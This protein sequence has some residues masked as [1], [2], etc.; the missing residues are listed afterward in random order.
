M[1]ETWSWVGESGSS[2]KYYVYELTWRPR[3][4]QEE[5]YIFGA[6]MHG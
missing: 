3:K 5:H 6:H 2:Y 1:S 4:D